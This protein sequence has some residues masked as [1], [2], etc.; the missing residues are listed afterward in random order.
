MASQVAMKRVVKQK[1]HIKS[2]LDFAEAR[3]CHVVLLCA[4]ACAELPAGA[5]AG[6]VSI[7]EVVRPFFGRLSSDAAICAEYDKTFEELYVKLLDRAAE[8]RRERDATL[9][10]EADLEPLSREERLG[11]GGLDPIEV[12]ESLPEP[13]QKAYEEKD[14]DALRA[15]IEGC[16]AAEGRDIMRKMAGSGL[17]VPAPGEEGTLLRDEEEEGEEGAAGDSAA[18]DAAA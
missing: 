7:R 12:F 15:Y 2:L 6:K 4:R 17:W 10:A 3:A 5:C 13:L 1:Y 11:P 14:V 8:K 18:G 9:A 16:P